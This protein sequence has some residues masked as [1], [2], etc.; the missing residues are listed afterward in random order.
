MTDIPSFGVAMGE[1]AEFDAIRRMIEIWGPDI[2][3]GLGDD[4]GAF[5]APRGER[6]LAST[7]ASVEGVHFRRDWLTPREIGARATAAAMSDL[8]AMSAMPIGLLLALGLPEEWRSDLDE[9]AAGVG[10][11]AVLMECTIIGGN[12][13]RARELSLTITVLGA[14]IA[15]LFRFAA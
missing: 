9:I 3:G 14:S 5:V 15:P 4:A 12:I 8:A 2:A 1:G 7:D 11:L 13:T 10:A 6:M